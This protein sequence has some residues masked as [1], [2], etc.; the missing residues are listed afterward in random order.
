MWTYH[1]Q[2]GRICVDGVEVLSYRISL[3]RWEAFEQVSALYQEIGESAVAFCETALRERAEQEFQ[4]SEDPQR[5]FHFP[6][7]RYRLEGRVTYEDLQLGVASVCL[8]AELK[9]LGCSARL[10]RHVEAHTWELKTGALLPP[11]QTVAFRFPDERIPRR[12]RRAEGALLEGER[13]FLLQRGERKELNL[14]VPTGWIRQR[15]RRLRKNSKKNGKNIQKSC[16][17]EKNMIQ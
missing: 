9:R 3:P 14:S 8:T 1:H 5:K 2:N 17:T 13:L 4:A 15:S 16:Q 12:I 6:A 11:E 10:Q 7:L